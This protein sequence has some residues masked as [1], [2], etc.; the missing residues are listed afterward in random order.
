MPRFADPPVDPDR[1][2]IRV[3]PRR[4]ARTRRRLPWL[5]LSLT[6]AGLVALLSVLAQEKA[7]REEAERPAVQVAEPRLL[8]P[9]LPWEVLPR[10]APLYTI[11]ATFLRGR[12]PAVEARRHQSGAREDVL[13]LG[14]LD[15]EGPVLR[16]VLRSGPIP[17]ANPDSFFVDL[18]RQAAEAGA[19]VERSLPGPDLAT[20]LGL[21]EVADVALNGGTERSC[22]AVRLYRPDAAFSLIGYACG[23]GGAPLVRADLAC[24]VDRL[25]LA[26]DADD[27]ALKA[28]FTGGQ[29]RRNPSC[30]PAAPRT[31][32]AGRR[33]SALDLEDLIA[34]E[35]PIGPPAAPA[36]S[37]PSRAK[38][39]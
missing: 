13:T 33:L 4:K 5:R 9:A 7:A 27:A 32:L 12:T 15:A 3:E 2:E 14:D 21:A 17:D 25:G 37:R 18:V 10:G 39:R 16:L 26:P 23:A 28:L 6:S 20:A 36:P 38:A 8:A 31:P 29:R 35:P 34:S 22:A 1:F 24:L 19:S 30:A 11:D